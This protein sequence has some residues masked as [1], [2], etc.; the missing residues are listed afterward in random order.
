M[1]ATPKY[2]LRFPELDDPA[3]VPTDMGELAADVEAAL[4]GVSLGGN[5]SG[6]PAA[7][8]VPAGTLYG[9]V[10]VQAVSCVRCRPPS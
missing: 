5:Q 1:G 6:R 3:D 10:D 8:A 7:S 4:G 2:G 9:A